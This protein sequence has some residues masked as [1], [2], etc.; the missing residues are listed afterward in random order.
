MPAVGGGVVG[1]F[2][3]LTLVF[4]LSLVEGHLPHAASFA[5]A[6]GVDE[7]RRLFYVA[8]TRAA[9]ELYLTYAQRAGHGRLQTPSRFLSELMDREE[10]PFTMVRPRFD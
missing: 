4:V 7:E 6:E 2:C 5:E 3:F 8:V 10:P 9:D 1:C